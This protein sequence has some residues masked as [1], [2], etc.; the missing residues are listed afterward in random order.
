MS[1]T[2]GNTNTKRLLAIFKKLTR[3]QKIQ[4]V[5]QLQKETREDRWDQLT[6]SLSRRFQGNPVSDEE[7]ASIVE[8]VRQERYEK[9]RS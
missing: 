6:E 2:E 1:K 3:F 7:I 8:E 4:I 5:Y 9:D